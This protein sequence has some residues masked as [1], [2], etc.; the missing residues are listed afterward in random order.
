[1]LAPRSYLF[2]AHH[3]NV[4]DKNDRKAKE[5]RRPSPPK[6]ATSSTM[7]VT[8]TA[9]TTSVATDTGSRPTTPSSPVVIPFRGQHDEPRQR[10]QVRNERQ[11]RSHA[12][13]QRTIHS[14]DAI[15][16]SVAA[17]LAITQIPTGPRYHTTHRAR[18]TAGQRLTVDAILQ[19]T[20][21][22]EKEYSI[23]LGRSPLDL[24]LSPQDELEDD[25]AGSETGQESIMSA[26]TLSS[27]SMP[28]L[29]GDCPSDAS[30]SMNSF[31]TTPSPRSRRSVPS[32]RLRALS[33]QDSSTD[34]HPLSSPT[35]NVDEL[36]FR[37]FQRETDDKEECSNTNEVTPRKSAF[38][39]N[40]TASLRALRSAA[41][42]FSSLKTP[43]ITPDDFLTRSIIT[44]DPRVP[45]TDE[46]MPPRL[47]DTPTPALRRYLNPTT[48]APIEAHVP[49]S[50]A[51]TT[52]AS[53]CTASIQME[54]YK[55]SRSAKG[56][57]PNV[58]SRRT[59]STQETLAEVVGPVARQREMREN[60][61]FI[62]IAVMEMAMRK[63]GKL[64]DHKPGRAKWALPPRKVPTKS[65][66]VGVDGVPVR[67]VALVPS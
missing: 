45:F 22:S 11:R 6:R 1:M 44:I 54:T 49:P 14:P 19:H 35:I 61:D 43:L 67:W 48:N 42:S 28:S 3:S 53:K 26:R 63:K 64:D 32:R 9:T 17:L 66:E 36:D 34:D 40:L 13:G 31:V 52:P 47:E 18:P 10:S 8:T 23:S 56:T 16:P 59:Q 37:V 12:R 62:R 65:Y 58:I 46:R 21:V 5:K 39:S 60:S 25:L 29:D 38:K 51:Q 55:I 4:S 33:T 24:L 41:K 50:L 30:P 2:T 15:S 20:G 57:S 7:S 27:E